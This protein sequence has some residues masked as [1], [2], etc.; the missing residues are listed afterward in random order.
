MNS[1]SIK[2]TTHT[3]GL[4][5]DCFQTVWSW[6]K[7]FPTLYPSCLVSHILC[8]PLS[9]CGLNK[10]LQSSRLLLTYGCP[11]RLHCETLRAAQCDNHSPKIN[12]VVFK[13]SY[14]FYPHISESF[15]VKVLIPFVTQLHLGRKTCL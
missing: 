9:H 2:S 1:A 8:L 3:G 4:R 6:A 14:I 12:A 5:S 7:C 15:G 10:A 11:A 13:H